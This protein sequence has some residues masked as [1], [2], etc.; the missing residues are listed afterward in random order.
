MAGI[1]DREATPEQSNQELLQRF[2]NTLQVSH[3]CQILVDTV[4]IPRQHSSNLLVAIDSDI[5][6]DENVRLIGN[7]L[8]DMF[9]NRT[10]LQIE[11][12]ENI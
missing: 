9:G 5:T 8:G 2:E 3:N 11:E 12:P 1:D 6:G 10:L 7:V 4:E